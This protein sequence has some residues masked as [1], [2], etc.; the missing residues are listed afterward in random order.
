MESLL[1]MR[2]KR[3]GTACWVCGLWSGAVAQ[4]NYTI[5]SA[6]ITH[7]KFSRLIFLIN[8]SDRKIL[9]FFSSYC[10]QLLLM[11]LG[12]HIIWTIRLLA[13]ILIQILFVCASEVCV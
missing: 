12:E 7:G 2:C 5:N 9:Q 1:V 6:S 3:T 8:V 13:V 4:T 10:S 11:A